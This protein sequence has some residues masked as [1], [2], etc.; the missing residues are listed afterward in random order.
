MVKRPPY[1]LKRPYTMK[2]RQSRPRPHNVV[3]PAGRGLCET[4]IKAFSHGEERR[5]FWEA[6]RPELHWKQV[7]RLES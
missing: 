2:S 3:N 6:T 5:P 7:R 4:S 1:V